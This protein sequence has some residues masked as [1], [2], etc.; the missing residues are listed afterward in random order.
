MIENSTWTA[1]TLKDEISNHFSDTNVTDD[2]IR[3]G[4]NFFYSL[5]GRVR[6]N[7]LRSDQRKN[8]AQISVT[9]SGYDLTQISDIATVDEGFIV[10]R[11]SVKKGNEMANV[12]KNSGEDGYYLMGNTLY[13]NS[14]SGS[15][16]VEYQAKSPRITS[17][18][19]LSDHTLKIDQDLEETVFRYVAAHFLEGQFRIDGLEPMQNDKFFSELTQYFNPKR[20]VAVISV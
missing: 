1:Q 4:L 2:N 20:R 5:L 7:A 15:I 11:G 9:S 18:T 3:L 12:G 16:V 17:S 10:Y 6:R 14:G 19:A 8:S 13:L